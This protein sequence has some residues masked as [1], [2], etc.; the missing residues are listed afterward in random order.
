MRASQTIAVRRF[1]ASLMGLL[2]LACIGAE[3][4]WAAGEARQPTAIQFFLRPTDRRERGP[5]S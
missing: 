2:G 4:S 3:I 1:L 5:P